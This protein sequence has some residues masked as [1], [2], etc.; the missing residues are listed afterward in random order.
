MMMSD[1]VMFVE[2]RRKEEKSERE[3]EM[4]M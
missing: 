4:K 1:P 3:S 2:W